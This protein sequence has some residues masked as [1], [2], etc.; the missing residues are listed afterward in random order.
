MSWTDIN[1]ARLNHLRN[2]EL[3]G[4]L[5]EVEQ[6]ELAALMAKVEADEVRVLAPA[7]QR[8]RS[9][10]REMEGEIATVQAQNQE[11]ARLLA[12]QQTLAEDG[13]RF[14]AEFERRRASILDGLA[15]LA[16]APLPTT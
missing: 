8:L 3:T 9:E 13:R 10:V 7:L 16:G 14:L 6:A 11:N 4:V 2:L 12:R 15:R 1:Q 5:S